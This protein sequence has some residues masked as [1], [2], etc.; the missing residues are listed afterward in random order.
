MLR[1]PHHAGVERVEIHLERIGNVARHHR[2]LEEVDVVEAL[3]EARRVVNVLQQRFAV[4]ALL[5]IDQMHG[6][7][8]RAV[9]HLGALD[10]H[11]VLGVL[12]AQREMTRRAT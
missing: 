7:T 8:G 11:V 6:G 9:M 2:P 4:L 3:D 5:D 10:H 1:R 12:A